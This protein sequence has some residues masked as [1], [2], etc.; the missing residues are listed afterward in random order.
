MSDFSLQQLHA[1]SSQHAAALQQNPLCGCFFCLSI[2]PAS[3]IEDWLDDEQTACCPCCGIDAV[4]AE[5]PEQAI[6]KT[7]LQQMK[8]YY[9]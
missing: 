4:I 2:F 1:Q 9:F 7:L 6:S 8:D 5:S 3:D